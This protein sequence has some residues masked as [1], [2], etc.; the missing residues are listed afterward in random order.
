MALHDD[1]L[2]Q[3][4]PKEQLK[5]VSLKLS[6]NED[7]DYLIKNFLTCLWT[8]RQHK[9]SGGN[10]FCSL[11]GWWNWLSLGGHVAYDSE[12]GSEVWATMGHISYRLGKIIAI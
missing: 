2:A 9:T 7:S 8:K 1:C 5:L 4:R 3:D 11:Q 6:E 10:I 12:E